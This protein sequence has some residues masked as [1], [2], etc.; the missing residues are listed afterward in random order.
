MVAGFCCPSVGGSQTG[1]GLVIGGGAKVNLSPDPWDGLVFVLPLNEVGNGTTDEFVDRSRNQLHGTGGEGACPT[2]TTG[3]F[4]QP[5][6]VFANDRE[7]ITLQPDTLDVE[8][9]FTLMFWTKINSFVKQRLFYTRGK[10]FSCAHTILN[11]PFAD[12]RLTDGAGGVIDYNVCDSDQLAQL[13]FY[14]VAFVVVPGERMSVYVDGEIKETTELTETETIAVGDCVLGDA[15]DG[16]LQ[17]VRLYP[18][19]LSDDH[20]QAVFDNYCDSGF[21]TVSDEEDP[22]VD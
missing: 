17:D 22:F 13:S 1:G 8:S 18:V 12:V 20:I 10:V 21:F 16:N 15:L 2:R 7:F 9:P 19:E 6:Q 5:S 3:V 14:H 11:Q 4:C